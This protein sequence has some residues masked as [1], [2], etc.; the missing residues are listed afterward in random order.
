MF[1][2]VI[3]SLSLDRM[4]CIAFLLF[5]CLDIIAAISITESCGLCGLMQATCSGCIN[6]NRIEPYI[7]TLSQWSCNSDLETDTDPCTGWHGIYCDAAND[8]IIQI[9]LVN[10]GLNGRF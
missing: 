3:S 10:L 7:S 6:G 8:N 4:L 5:I 1:N 2:T 9:S